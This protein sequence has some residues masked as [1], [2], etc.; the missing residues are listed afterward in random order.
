LAYLC[1]DTGL[2]TELEEPA[3][4]RQGCVVRIV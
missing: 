1:F 3:N 4:I 2:A